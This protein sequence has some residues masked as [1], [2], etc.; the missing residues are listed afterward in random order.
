MPKRS[1]CI[2]VPKIQGEA[3]IILA[4]KLRIFNKELEIRRDKSFL[5]IPL[6]HEPSQ[7][8]SKRFKK[9][10]P[11]IEVT[12]DF[13]QERAKKPRTLGELL[14]G[15][16]PPHLLAS[17]PHSA[18]F[19]GDIAIIE[20]PPELEAYKTIIGNTILEANRNLR[21]V[22]AKAS[23]VS[24]AYRL[25]EFR[26]IAGENKTATIHKEHG[27]LYYVDLAKAYFSPRLSH[28]H[29]RVASLVREGETVV[30]LFAGVGPFAVQIAKTHENVR[31]FAI[32]LNPHS[33][34]FLRRNVRLNRV[35]CKVYPILGDAREVVKKKLSG[36]AN[37]V[38]MNLPETA[39]E[40][41]DVACQAL[42][43]TGGILHFYTFA[44]APDSLEN[45]QSRFD[46]AVE[47]RGRKVQKVLLSRYIRATAP[48]E[49][50][51]VLDA[52]IN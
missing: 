9:Q 30:D 44:K 32:D 34:E 35:D 12:T 21:T 49:W 8:M 37:R 36:V 27:C 14:D 51:A 39:I 41:V 5:Y 11:S 38:I 43:P 47:K 19:V 29:D 45:V 20:I 15:K 42:K 6:L 1:A 22:L 2:K 26:V 46:K 31:V 40:F 17:L 24:G 16:L 33:V 10:V 23:A 4:N 25:R 48:Y 28:E 50:Q 18:D 13:F 7:G 3:T 52:K